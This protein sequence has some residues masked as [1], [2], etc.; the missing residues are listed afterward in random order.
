MSFRT[1]LIVGIESGKGKGAGFPATR[2]VHSRGSAD[3]TLVLFICHSIQRA[4][5]TYRRSGSVVDTEATPSNCL[6]DSS[7]KSKDRRPYRAP[8]RDA[9]RPSSLRRHRGLLVQ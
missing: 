3:R 2:G 9:G 8:P 6:A 4:F 5:E 1:I 7:R